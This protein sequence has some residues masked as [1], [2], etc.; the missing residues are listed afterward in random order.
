MTE[1]IVPE[2]YTY[3]WAAAGLGNRRLDTQ[4]SALL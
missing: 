4:Q 3:H 1:T 2:T